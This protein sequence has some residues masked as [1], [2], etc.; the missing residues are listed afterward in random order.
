MEE[1]PE[2]VDE[3]LHVEAD[4]TAQS[5]R[6]RIIQN[7]VS[8]FS[9]RV[10]DT[11]GTRNDSYESVFTEASSIEERNTVNCFRGDEDE[12]KNV[13]NTEITQETKFVEIPRSLMKQRQK[14]LMNFVD[15]DNQCN[16]RIIAKTRAFSNS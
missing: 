14:V 1:V 6:W 13:S 11:F 4:N 16:P 9:K 10:V 15:F 12:N 5:S 2:D 8:S 7:F 3:L